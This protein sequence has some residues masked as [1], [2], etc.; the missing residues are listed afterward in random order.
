MQVKWLMAIRQISGRRW[1]DGEMDREGHL[2]YQDG[3]PL[4]GLCHCARNEAHDVEPAAPAS[5]EA[6][7]RE[8]C[9]EDNG[10]RSCCQTAQ[11]SPH[12]E[13]CRLS[14]SVQ[15]AMLDHERM[16]S[17]ETEEPA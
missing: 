16:Y 1:H 5:W 11:L 3:K 8:R 15:D 10:P 7:D 14:P 12:R 9:E 6:Y 13:D 2:A 4:L 17:H